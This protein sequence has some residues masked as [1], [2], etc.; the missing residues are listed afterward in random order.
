MFTGIIEDQGVVLGLEVN[1]ENLNITL[2]SKLT[3]EFKIDQ[4][5]SHNGI[6]LTIVEIKDSAY[7]VTAI[8]ETIAK[9]NIGKWQIGEV[10]NLER[11]MIIGARLDGHMIQGHIDQ[12]GE[13]FKI[14]KTNGSWEY[15]FQYN[16]SDN[17]TVE[18]G[19][20]AVN[21][22]SLTVVRSNDNSFSVA[23]I[24]YTYN[25]TNFQNLTIG[26]VVNLEFDVLGKYLAKML[27]K[28]K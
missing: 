11:A 10:V 25:H 16:P 3:S 21:G 12:V 5:V 24:P 20:I 27:P 2:S 14:D 1:R 22:I 17:L 19:S 8:K 4:S 18:K 28:Y 26:S 13:C 6:C 23:I 15:T 9:T 7:T